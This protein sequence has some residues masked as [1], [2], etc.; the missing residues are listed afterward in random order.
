MSRLATH[1]YQPT[2]KG[3]ARHRDDPIE[4][5][6]SSPN[7]GTVTIEDGPK[8]VPAPSGFSFFGE[9]MTTTAPDATQD[10]PLVLVFVLDASQIPAGQTAGTL[11]VFRN[12]SYVLACAGVPGVADPDPCVS[13]R[14]TLPDGDAQI[15]VLTS[16]AS[17][18]NLG[19]PAPVADGGGP[20]AVVEG[21]TVQLDAAGSTGIDPL[22]LLWF[23]DSSLDDGSLAQ[24]TF[25][26][27]DD[28]GEELTLQV[29]DATGMASSATTTVTVT[30]ADPA[31]G[32]FS[33]TSSRV[34]QQLNVSAPFTDPGTFDTHTAVIDWGDGTTSPGTVTEQTGRARSRVRTPTP[35][36]ARTR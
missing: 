22:A 16:E 29:T 18:W 13:D 28:G 34:G 20:Y 10:E 7:G 1:P 36:P 35:R 2:S 33:I 25:A 26:G 9:Q 4:T 23:P 24:P 30:N 14:Q 5:Q 19:F 32:A 3:T 27:L 15:T 17:D 12:G 8:D 31:V 6:V 21:S 11:A